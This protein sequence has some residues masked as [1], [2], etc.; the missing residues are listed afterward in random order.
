MRNDEPTTAPVI[1]PE[2]DE[3]SQ[4][5][6]FEDLVRQS[7]QVTVQCEHARIVDAYHGLAMAGDNIINGITTLYGSKLDTLIGVS[8]YSRELP[9]GRTVMVDIAPDGRHQA[10]LLA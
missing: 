1:N 4:P 2:D 6:G 9:D 5:I 3:L 8:T 7:P 10:S